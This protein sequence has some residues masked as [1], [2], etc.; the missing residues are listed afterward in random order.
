MQSWHPAVNPAPL[1][2]LRG[3]YDSKST[4]RAEEVFQP[5]HWQGEWEQQR[6]WGRCSSALEREC[7]VRS[8]R[9]TASS[10]FESRI[11]I[12]LYMPSWLLSPDLP[13][14][15][16]PCWNYHN[17]LSGQTLP[18]SNWLVISG[19]FR[20][21]NTKLVELFLISTSPSCCFP[22]P[23]LKLG[24]PKIVTPFPWPCFAPFLTTLISSMVLHSASK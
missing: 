5:V 18:L 7:R 1:V 22:A 8:S 2:P 24:N 20:C 17:P 23:V 10:T 16:C 15:I 14:P 19:E 13:F 4:V 3:T 11:Q 12:C 21:M 6:T 9:R